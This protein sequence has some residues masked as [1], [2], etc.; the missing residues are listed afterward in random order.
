MRISLIGD[1]GIEIY[2]NYKVKYIV[3][4]ISQIIITIILLQENIH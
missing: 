1:G 4:I 2:D 3:P